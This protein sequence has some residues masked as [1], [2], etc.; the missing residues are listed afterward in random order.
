MLATM[1]SA[2]QVI[3]LGSKTHLLSLLILS[4]P[5]RVISNKY[6]AS[7][8]L[9]SPPEFTMRG[10]GGT[11]SQPLVLSPECWYQTAGIFLE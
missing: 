6:L 3:I 5:L 4:Q 11:G 7:P 2:P 9:C 8:T 10:R 1:H